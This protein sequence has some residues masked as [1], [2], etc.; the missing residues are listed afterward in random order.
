[1]VYSDYALL[2]QDHNKNILAILNNH[3]DIAERRIARK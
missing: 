1:M 3:F 2:A